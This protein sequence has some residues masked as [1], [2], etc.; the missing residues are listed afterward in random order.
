M[1]QI[2]VLVAAGVVGGLQVAAASTQEASTLSP[3][4]TR[5]VQ[6]CV[7]APQLTESSDFV[8]RGQPESAADTR[9]KALRAG[10]AKAA[11]PGGSADVPSRMQSS[12]L[13]PPARIQ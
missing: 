9:T 5:L 6:S 10:A 8:L 11:Q 13:E 12:T 4:D 3:R 1:R 2:I 7:A